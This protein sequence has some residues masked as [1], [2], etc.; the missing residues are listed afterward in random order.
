M[1]G[2]VCAK[3]EGVPIIIKIVNKRR[4]AVMRSESDLMMGIIREN[5]G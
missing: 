1:L 5:W 4:L 2:C 3:G